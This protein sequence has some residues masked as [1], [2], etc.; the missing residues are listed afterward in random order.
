MKLSQFHPSQPCIVEA[1]W[2]IVVSS[3]PVQDFHQ[4]VVQVAS[5]VGDNKTHSENY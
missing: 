5:P 3:P 2:H 1:S 4:A